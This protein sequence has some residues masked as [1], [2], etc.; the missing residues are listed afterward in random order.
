[1]NNKLTKR[2]SEIMNFFWEHGAMFV[3]ELLSKFSEPRPHVNTLSTMVRMLEEKGFLGHKAYG[4]TYQY[5]PIVSQSEYSKQSLAGM[6]RKFFS[7]SYLNVVSS[8]VKDDKVSIEE[9]KALIDQLEKE[10][11][12]TS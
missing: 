1:M 10:K 7:G 4:N 12:Q 9:L 5:Y 8:F 6:V 3:K 2:E 11:N